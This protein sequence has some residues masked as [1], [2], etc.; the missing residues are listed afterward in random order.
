MRKICLKLLN[1]PLKWEWDRIADVKCWWSR[2]KRKSVLKTGGGGGVTVTFGCIM[3][4]GVLD[5]KRR[6]FL[7]IYLLILF[8]LFYFFWGGRCLYTNNHS[9]ILEQIITKPSFF[10]F[11][12][13][14]LPS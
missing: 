4:N 1:F 5:L 7:F 6:S 3:Y 14:N 10:E 9:I 12:F 8:L 2:S 11:C 13:N